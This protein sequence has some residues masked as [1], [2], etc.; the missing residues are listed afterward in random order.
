MPDIRKTLTGFTLK[1]NTLSRAVKNL[2]CK[3][4]GGGLSGR[5]KT[6]C[7]T[8]C[9]NKSTPWNKGLSGYTT[10]WNGGK[11][12]D[13][14]KEKMRQAKLGKVPT[15]EHR[16]KQSLAL[17][18]RMPKNLSQL[19]NSGQKSH[20]WKGGVTK[21]NEIARKGKE[22]KRWRFDVYL[23]DNFTCQKCGVRNNKL[24][25]HHILNFAEHK[26]LRFSVDNGL[27]FCE[28]CHR[29]FHKQYGSSKNGYEQLNHYLCQK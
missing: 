7:G 28:V 6:Y 3:T 1:D 13:K 14:A 26:N 8:E 16:L 27:T 17:K 2:F 12:S 9:R 18:G 5:N 22:Y 15:V 11:H 19:D 25:P 10:K 24:H 23:R 21:Q 20:W 29:V 4:C